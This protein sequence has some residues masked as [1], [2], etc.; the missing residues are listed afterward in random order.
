M[1]YPT[2]VDSYET[3]IGN[4]VK[5]GR[6][7]VAR[8]SEAVVDSF[9]MNPTTVDPA[10]S[11]AVVVRTSALEVDPKFVLPVDVVADPV[12]VSTTVEP[13]ESLTVVV[14]IP[15]AIEDE[16]G[17]DCAELAIDVALLCVFGMTVGTGGAFEGRL[18]GAGPSL[19]GHTLNQVQASFVLGFTEM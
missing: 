10:E 6:L 4:S 9:V 12:M 8:F 17:P 11:V 15:A 7:L 16:I 14:K 1:L 19:P 5:V 3:L 13:L 2:E 18:G